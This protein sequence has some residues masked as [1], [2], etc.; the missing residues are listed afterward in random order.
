MSHRRYAIINLYTGKHEDPLPHL[1]IAHERFE[2][3]A[4][5]HPDQPEYRKQ[6]AR[7][8]ADIGAALSDRTTD[9]DEAVGAERTAIAMFEQLLR[10][11]PADEAVVDDLARTLVSLGVRSSEEHGRGEEAAEHMKRARDLMQGLI[12]KHPESLPSGSNW[13]NCMMVCT[14][15]SSDINPGRTRPFSHHR[16]P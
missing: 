9:R 2:G 12:A 3:L 16:R 11:Q 6:V 15:T 7:T 14:Q 13:R 8:L 5:Q 4:R 1:R 10:E